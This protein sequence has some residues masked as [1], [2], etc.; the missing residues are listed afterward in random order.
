MSESTDG[1]LLN[2]PPVYLGGVWRL[3]YTVDV[4]TD[5]PRNLVARSRELRA[6]TFVK[7]ASL[8]YLPRSAGVEMTITAASSTS[9]TVSVTSTAGVVKDALVCYDQ[10][11]TA[12]NFRYG[13]VRKVVDAT[14]LELY[15]L[16]PGISTTGVLRTMDRGVSY[17]T[18]VRPRG[19]RWE[20]RG[21]M[22][23]P[24]RF[25]ASYVANVE[26][27]ALWWATNPDREG[28]VVDWERSPGPYLARDGNSGSSE[29]PTYAERPV[30]PYTQALTVRRRRRS[31]H[32]RR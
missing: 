20:W 1:P 31:V 6:G 23:A 9:R 13:R 10:D 12:D 16:M 7:D 17:P 30:H 28:P 11:A 24:M 4:S 2:A 18:H 19:D 29:N 22:F 14:T 25:H 15:H 5:P 8:V 21:T 3:Y 26:T 32:L 27:S